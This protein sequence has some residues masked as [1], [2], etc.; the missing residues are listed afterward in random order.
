MGG[1]IVGGVVDIAEVIGGIG[2]GDIRLV[3]LRRALLHRLQR[4]EDGGQNFVLNI[5]QAQRLFGE[6]LALR[7]HK[8][9]PVAHVAHAVIQQICIIG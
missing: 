3:Q 8:G 5:D 2:M 9:Y 7:R 4:V 6:G 1:D